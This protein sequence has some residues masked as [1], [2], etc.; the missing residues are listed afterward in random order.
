MDI[1]SDDS[2]NNNINNIYLR[3][4]D[5]NL[6]EYSYSNEFKFNIIADKKSKRVNI[7]EITGHFF[8]LSSINSERK[9]ENII[10]I[11][12]QYDDE[13]FDICRN[14]CR[15]TNC[16]KGSGNN[17]VHLDRFY[18]DSD[19]RGNGTGRETLH[20]FKDEI[21]NLLKEDVRYIALFPDPITNDKKF[22]SLYD[23]DLKQRTNKIKKL[24][25]FYS[26]LGFKEM[27]VKSDY[28]YLDLYSNYD[29]MR[30]YSN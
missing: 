8:D 11:L 13:T 3:E 1:G 26:S 25:N 5:E 30:N 4:R 15:E 20:Y 28:M 10:N 9:T 22:D 27:K 17:I 14:L 18:I 7:G 23:M 24:K 21:C 2:D 19:Y 12:N 16:I 29:N 6:K